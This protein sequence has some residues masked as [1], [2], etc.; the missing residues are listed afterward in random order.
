MLEALDSYSGESV[1]DIIHAE[2]NTNLETVLSI[3]KA[4]ENSPFRQRILKSI[5]SGPIDADKLDYLD[6]DC[7]H[8]GVSFGGD[9]D[10]GRLL[11]NLTVCFSTRDGVLD[12]AE[13]GIMEKA[14]TVAES[15][16]RARLEMFRQV[17]WHH[18][19]RSL[20]A[21]LTFVVRRILIRLQNENKMDQICGVLN[22]FCLSPICSPSFENKA[23]EQSRTCDLLNATVE[24]SVEYDESLNI[25]YSHLSAN[26][27]ALISFL[28][29]FAD[30]LGKNVLEMIRHRQLFTRVAVLSHSIEE[31]R[32]VSIYTRFR[33]ER[34]R[35]YFPQQETRRERLEEMILEKCD[36]HDKDLIYDRMQGKVPLI[37]FDVPLK[38]LRDPPAKEALWYIPEEKL[39]FS[40]K[41]IFKKY[42]VAQSKIQIE[43]TVFDRMV[44]KIRV[45]AHPAI[46]QQV[47]EKM[48]SHE[49]ITCLLNT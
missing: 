31:S 11:R 19:V 49:I 21:M 8:T 18:T 35:G 14:H 4:N 30:E 16:S 27:D 15:I 28:W 33:E 48:T 38:A 32:F 36:L 1:A 13:I 20:K 37:L 12:V 2:W 44:G 29:R 3:L 7:I 47:L 42:S 17:Y 23:T 40:Q 45:L 5:I 39:G 46:Q 6:R 41:D 22:G 43:S 25:P 34:L 9:I 26:D 24:Q 10:R